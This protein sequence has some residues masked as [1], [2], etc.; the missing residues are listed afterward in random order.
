LQKPGYHPTQKPESL[1]ERIIEASSKI[2]DKVL[3][4]FMRSGTTCYVA[5]RLGRQFIG[6]EK[7]QRYYS[8][9]KKRVDGTA[10]S[11]QK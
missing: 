7:E 5:K 3:D 10:F 1:L 6:I 2:G 8:I 9:A 4:P 11:V